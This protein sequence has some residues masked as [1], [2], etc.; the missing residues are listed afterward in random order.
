M[1]VLDVP[2]TTRASLYVYNDEGDVD[3]LVESLAKAEKFFAI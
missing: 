3:T 2:A 1:R